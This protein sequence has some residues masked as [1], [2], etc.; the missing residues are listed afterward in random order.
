M[1]NHTPDKPSVMVTE[2]KARS[3]L[4]DSKVFTYAL[5]AYVGC[6]HGCSYCYARFMKKY[7]RHEEPWGYFVD[8][9]VNAA[10]VLK[11]EIGKKKKGKVWISGVCDPYQPIEKTYQITRK[12][13][14]V[15]LENQWPITI[16]TRSSLVLRDLDL[17]KQFQDVEVGLSVPTGNDRVREIFESSSPPI[18]DRLETLKT[19]H[20][21]GI[22]TFAMIAP[23]LPRTET[24]IE[25]LAGNVDYIN[26]DKLNY[27]YADHIFKKLNREQYLKKEYST[28]T[29][30]QLKAFCD[31][32]DIDCRIVF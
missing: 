23:I 3:I 26:I 31:R 27:H 32:L 29:A 10:E 6:Q 13:L 22:K 4:S 19:L 15:L 11:K 16:Q 28:K 12:C 14:E 25:S 30:Q 1:Q 18:P 8:V 20:Q 24:L 21:E 7:T 9:K 2:K 5:N 17:L